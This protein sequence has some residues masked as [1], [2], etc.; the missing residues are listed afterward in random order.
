MES[1]YVIA[2][3]WHNGELECRSC[4]AAEIIGGY[5]YCKATA[6]YNK[7]SLV[8]VRCPTVGRLQSCPA[9]LK[10]AIPQSVQMQL[11]IARPALIR[12]AMLYGQAHRAESFWSEDDVTF[13]VQ[14]AIR[15]ITNDD[16]DQRGYIINVVFLR[17]AAAALCGE[18]TKATEHVGV[19]FS[20]KE[21]AARIID[22]ILGALDNE[23]V[24]VLEAEGEEGNA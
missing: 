12:L 18:S 2:A 22:G 6:I 9:A 5:I 14:P 11:N 4:V 8:I 15:R 23:L 16:P 17:L 13:R 24:R 20:T 7:G 21:G 1:N 10:T 3:T 19:L